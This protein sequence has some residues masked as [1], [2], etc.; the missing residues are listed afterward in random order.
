MRATILFALI[1]F[2]A[3]S[4]FADDL[5]MPPWRKHKNSTFQQ[6]DFRF[7]PSMSSRK[8]S[9]PCLPLDQNK[10]LWGQRGSPDQASNPYQKESGI[11]LEYRTL[12]AM[13]DKINWLEEYYNRQGVWHLSLDTGGFTSIDFI[14]P[15]KYSKAADSKKT[16]VQVTYHGSSAAPRA[17]IL[18]LLK[19]QVEEY[20]HLLPSIDYQSGIMPEGWIQHTFIFKADFCPASENIQ[21][22]PPESGDIYIDNVIVD[23][24]CNEPGK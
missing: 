10:V 13:T 12:W 4:V 16:Q 9:Q 24:L 6:W 23:T 11:C 15:G 21:I 1:Y 19:E 17:K 14:V 22:F 5:D 3:T 20:A 18:I 8:S 2:T 7:A